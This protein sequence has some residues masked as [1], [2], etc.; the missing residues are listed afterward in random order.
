MELTADVPHVTLHSIKT[1]KDHKEFG[2]LG[3][4]GLIG[5]WVSVREDILPPSDK[6]MVFNNMPLYTNHSIAVV[7][8]HRDN[9]IVIYRGEQ[10]L[11]IGWLS[12]MD[13]NI[14]NYVAVQQEYMV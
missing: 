7:V 14:V 12:E 9:K 5:S 4:G 8:G 11:Y 13:Y 2:D 6:N 10:D 1:T 3:K